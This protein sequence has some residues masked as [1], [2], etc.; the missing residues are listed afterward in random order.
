MSNNE[1]QIQLKLPCFL[2]KDEAERQIIE[3][4]KRIDYYITEYSIGHLAQKM[5]EE[6]Y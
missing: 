2:D 4:S 5:R 6:E 1:E 3:K